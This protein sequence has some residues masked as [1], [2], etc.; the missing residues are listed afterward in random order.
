[1][2]IVFWEVVLSISVEIHK[3]YEHVSLFKEKI[4][5]RN[6]TLHQI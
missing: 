5:P 6:F 1:M 3:R 4:T 2:H